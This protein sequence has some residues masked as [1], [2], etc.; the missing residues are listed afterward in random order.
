MAEAGGRV[1][2]TPADA[3]AASKSVFPADGSGPAEANTAE[4]RGRT[5]SS[6]ESESCDSGVMGEFGGKGL[7]A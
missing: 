1:E 3:G 6:S 7:A 5:N 2:G 4:V